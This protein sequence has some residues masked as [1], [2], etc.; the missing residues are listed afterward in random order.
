MK[1]RFYALD[2]LRG[3]CALAVVVFHMDWLDSVTGL[4]FFRGSFL[5]VEFFFVLSGFVLAHRFQV[6]DASCFSHFM[7]ARFFRLYPL[8]I[9]MFALVVLYQF[10][11]MFVNS[12]YGLNFGIEP[13]T[14]KYAVDEIIPHLLLIQSW[15][16]SFNSVSF[17]GSSWS[18]SIEFYMYALLFF[19][20]VTFRAHQV[21]SWIV[22]SLVAFGFLFTKLGFIPSEVLR[23]LS[24]FFGG[25]FFYT[26]YL[27][28]SKV[29][30]SY[31]TA[32]FLELVLLVTIIAAIQFKHDY[33]SI[34]VSAL[35]MLAVLLL[36]FE[37]GFFSELLMKK[38]MQT[39]GVLSYSVYLTHGVLLLYFRAMLTIWD[40]YIA[41]EMMPVIDGVRYMNFGSTVAN[42]LGVLLILVLSVL[43]SRY[44]HKYIELTG[45]RLGAQLSWSQPKH[46]KVS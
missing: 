9:A 8:H 43:L 34:V 29:S 5:F 38:S 35:F 11:H 36:A 21:L 27:T 28:V 39:L 46:S 2:G 41:I 31:K 14:A 22:I 18:I 17:N 19:S 24:C 26:V 1:E 23:G 40:E 13:F 33:R 3:V 10:I 15:S 42:N 32:S 20:I 25:A 7:K 12:V 16:S 45:Q 44:T 37:S 4:D 6:K 30:L